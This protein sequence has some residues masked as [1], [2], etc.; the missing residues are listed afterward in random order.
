MPSPA[1]I[2]W[3]LLRPKGLRL[4]AADRPT[5]RSSKVWKVSRPREIPR[6][7]RQLD[8]TRKKP[9][10]RVVWRPCVQ[11]RVSEIEKYLLALPKSLPGVPKRRNEP[12]GPRIVI[13]G[14][15]AKRGSAG[16]MPRDAAEGVWSPQAP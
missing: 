1:E 9:P 6:S 11:E 12:K 4:S 7:P 14:G 8:S 13:S 3:M 15:W 16:V 2:V 5:S 10:K